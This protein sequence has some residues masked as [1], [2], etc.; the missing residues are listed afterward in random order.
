MD[1]SSLDAVPPKYICYSCQLPRLFKR[2]TLLST[3]VSLEGYP[4]LLLL[5]LK[6]TLTVHSHPLTFTCALH[7]LYLLY[8]NKK[9][10]ALQYF[11][12]ELQ[13]IISRLGNRLISQFRATAVV[14][15]EGCT[16]EWFLQS[17]G[18]QSLFFNTW[19]DGTSATKTC[20]RPL[21]KKR[22]Q[23]LT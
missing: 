23:H 20:K 11:S 17:Y 4:S 8:A 16:A 9:N 21:A 6:L 19:L 13:H 15:A 5:P 12:R 2:S 18:E 10:N 7:D 3:S 22:Q 14:I 1:S